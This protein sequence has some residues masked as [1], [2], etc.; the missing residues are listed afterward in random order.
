MK[1]LFKNIIC[2]KSMFS[3]L[4]ASFILIII[5]IS[6]FHLITNQIYKRNMENEITKNVSERFGNVVKEYEL[7]FSDVKNKLL[8]D[9]Y[10]E[11]SNVLKAPKGHDY[12]NTQMFKKMSKYLLTYPYMKDFIVYIKDFDYVITLNG[13]LE[14]EAFFD[15]F[16]ESAFYTEYF[17]QNEMKKNFMY[18]VYPLKEFILNDMLNQSKS[19]KL[20][21]IVLKHFTETDFILIVLFDINQFSNGLDADF[22]ND[23]FIYDES[24]IRV[25]PEAVSLDKRDEL[26]ISEVIHDNDLSGYHKVENGYLFT[27]K[28]PQNSLTYCKYY[29]DTVIRNQINETNKIMTVIIFTAMLISIL[30]SFYIVKKFN[31]PVK[32]IYQLIRGSK[33]AADT[34]RDIIDLK[35]IKDRVAG[36]VSQN[37][38]YV[39]DINEKN[40]LLKNYFWQTRLKNILVKP[41]ESGR[42]PA[43]YSNYAVVLFR[44]HYRKSYYENIAK[45]TN[46]GTFVLKDLIDLY[47]YEEFSDA[48]TFQM[49]EKQIVSIVGVKKD[50]DTIEDHV[51]KIVQKLMTEDEYVYFTVTYSGVYYNSSELHEV[52]EKVVKTQS[53]RKLI[54]KTQIL[55]ENTLKKKLDGFYFSRDQQEQF[56]N[57]LAN[58]RKDDCLQL[59][60]SIFDYNLKKETNELCIYL[61]YVEV[62]D[63]CSN[64]LMQQFNEIPGNLPLTNDHFNLGQSES[65]DD[66]KKRYGVVIA[67]CINYISKNKK[68]SDYIVDYVKNYI[69]NN[70]S[71]DISVDLLADK[72]KISRT[73]LSRYFKNNTGMNLSDYLNAYRMKKACVLLQNSFLMI[74]DIAPQVGISNIS[75]F[76]R[77]FKSY[78]GKTP[79]DYRK[80]N[81]Q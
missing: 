59:L 10:I 17:W 77:L 32:H 28:S 66:Y 13:T 71:N 78:T 57:L 15:R 44:I 21:P 58:G 42:N 54:G 4:I 22:I 55:S 37:T 72:L 79:N 56:T 43:E 1:E 2:L 9:F 8:M 48:V 7:C 75:T 33:D 11:Y 46:E 12:A 49:D 20:M 70:Y 81:I 34:G 67:E 62:I 23:F 24:A 69:N 5:V 74:K 65:V 76:M 6:S 30:L 51:N 64:V 41:D 63:C 19:Q 61:L 53:Y 45:E 68:Q 35:N 26:F 25:Y 27:Y 16:Y 47:I 38:N 52:Y 18:K 80:S 36:I 29:P 60:D 3:K 39:K 40:S 31:N 14:R 50:A 73:Y